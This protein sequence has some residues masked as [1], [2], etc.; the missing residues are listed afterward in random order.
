MSISWLHPALY[1][2]I[3]EAFNGLSRLEVLT[4]KKDIERYM[5]NQM[6]N[7]CTVSKY[8]ELKHEII[9]YIVSVADSM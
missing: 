2:D 1:L 4:P 9:S 5:R 6:S 7:W 3:V 8:P